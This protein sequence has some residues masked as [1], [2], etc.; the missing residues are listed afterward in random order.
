[1]N[2]P[3]CRLHCSVATRL[4][5]ESQVHLPGAQVRPALAR[6]GWPSSQARAAGGGRRPASLPGASPPG[7]FYI[8]DGKEFPTDNFETL[9]LG[10]FI[11]INARLLL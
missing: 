10:N 5:R 2:H 9:S 4:R 3:D 7:R 6:S 1:M 11:F 8:A